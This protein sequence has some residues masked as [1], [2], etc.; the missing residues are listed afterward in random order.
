M[1]GRGWKEEGGRGGGKG[2]R[3]EGED[4]ERKEEGEGWREEGGKEGS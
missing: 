2:V 4:G 3:R 1:R